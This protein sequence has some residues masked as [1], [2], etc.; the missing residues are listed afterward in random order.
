MT[1]VSVW[2]TYTFQMNLILRNKMT[3][4]KKYT[5]SRWIFR[6]H[7][8]CAPS[9][10]ETLQCNVVS[11]WL[12]AYTK[13][14]LLLYY[15]NNMTSI[16]WVHGSHLISILSIWSITSQGCRP[17]FP[18]SIREQASSTMA[19]WGSYH[20]DQRMAKKTRHHLSKKNVVDVKQN[21]R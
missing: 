14:S 8:V 2:N 13:W 1:I 11:H 21:T 5:L 3:S 9:Q 4:A 7:F 12:G 10:W 16:W 15:K 19:S 20:R 18:A 6:D 17:I